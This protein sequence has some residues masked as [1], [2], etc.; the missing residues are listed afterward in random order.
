[1]YNLQ[2]QGLQLIGVPCG[3]GNVLTNKGAVCVLLR[4]RDTSLAF[5]NAHLAAHEPKLLE[6]NANYHRIREAI[7]SRMD[8]LFLPH[9]PPPQIASVQSGPAI[10]RVNGAVETSSAPQSSLYWEQ[11][12]TASGIPRDKM[13]LPFFSD[14]DHDDLK[15]TF[16]PYPRQVSAEY[17]QRRSDNHGLVAKTASV[18]NS[19]KDIWPFDAVFFFGDLNYRVKGLSRAQMDKFVSHVRDIENNRRSRME[20]KFS[21]HRDNENGVLRRALKKPNYM[22]VSNKA[23]PLLNR[24]LNFDQLNEQREKKEAFADFEEGVITFLPTYKFD[25]HSTRYDS[26][27]KQRCPSWTDRVL[28][29]TRSTGDYLTRKGADSKNNLAPAAIVRCKRKNTHFA[30]KEIKALEVE[31]EKYCSFDVRHSDHR[32]VAAT[33]LL[34]KK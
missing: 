8:D 33:F 19:G 20:R 18:Y 17:Q 6:R 31:V 28:F 5:V 3:V 1:L 21:N 10:P 24:V 25:P 32:P 4:I 13:L 34:K 9:I 2:V 16:S 26:S 22:T 15:K 23:L 29:R 11:I 27:D 12:L 7:L 30:S 14:S